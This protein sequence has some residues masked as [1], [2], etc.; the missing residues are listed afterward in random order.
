MRRLLP[1]FALLV[2]ASLASGLMLLFLFPAMNQKNK[3]PSPA[4][5]QVAPLQLTQDQASAF[6]RLALK[7]IRREYPNKLDHVFNNEKDVQGPKALHPAFYGCFDWHS[8]V[9]GH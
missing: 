7:G 2:V 6:A 9:H 1:S 8:A 3:G 5:R 4:A